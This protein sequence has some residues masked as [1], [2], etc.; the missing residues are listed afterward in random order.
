MLKKK[1]L[2]LLL[3][4][5]SII[6]IVFIVYKLK[7]QREISP[8]STPISEIGV[9]YKGLIPGKT[10]EDEVINKLG[11]PMKESR[12]ENIKILEYKSTNPNYNNIAKVENNTLSFF[13]EIVTPDDN[14]KITDI[15][16]KYGNYEKVLY[17][18]GSETGFNLYVYPS[19]GIAYMGH[20]LSGII[21]E[22]WFFPP[23]SFEE[24]RKLYAPDYPDQPIPRGH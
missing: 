9:D 12:E 24:F 2:I 21:T 8:V 10:S 6:S 19:K 17:P 16:Q 14:I 22:I 20:Q 15:N 23:T 5:L 18:S 4:V 11:I 13:K 1:K 3:F 7:R